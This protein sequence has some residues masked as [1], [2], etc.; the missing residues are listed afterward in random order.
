MKIKTLLG[1]MSC[2]VLMSGCAGSFGKSEAELRALPDSY[3]ESRSIYQMTQAEN[4]EWQRRMYNKQRELDREAA[5][6]FGS[7]PAIDRSKLNCENVEGSP[8]Y[9]AKHGD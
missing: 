9:K 8:E 4:N 5:C 6:V 1:V 2:A 7:R 3:F